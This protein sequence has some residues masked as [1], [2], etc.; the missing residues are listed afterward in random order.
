MWTIEPPVL[1]APELYDRMAERRQPVTT[2]ELVAIRPQIC[3]AYAEYAH[4]P[5]QAA[6]LTP[7]TLPV[8]LRQ[9]LRG[10]YTR[11]RETEAELYASIKLSAERCPYCGERTITT[12]DHYLPNAVFPEFSVLPINLV[13][14]CSDCNKIKDTDYVD[15]AGRPVFLHAYFDDLGTSQVV[16]ASLD[17]A[18]GSALLDFAIRCPA[19][20]DPAL[21]EKV[22]RQFS[23]LKLDESYRG[24]AEQEASIHAYDVQDQ[25]ADGVPTSTISDGLS[26]AARAAALV[27]GRNHWRPITLHA[28]AADEGFCQGSCTPRVAC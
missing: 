28:L 13:P 11:F 9:K 27:L 20:V 17:T 25:L 18:T 15:G 14:A 6:R 1:D 21:A 10:N 22:E 23:S 3:G 8:L 16:H 24:W 5:S 19:T 2:A 4:A 12:V 26:R 7:L